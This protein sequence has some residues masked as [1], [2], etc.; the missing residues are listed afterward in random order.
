M[1]EEQ[2]TVEDVAGPY[3]QKVDDR[4]E[5]DKSVYEKPKGKVFPLDLDF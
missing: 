1:A 3:K 4:F 2:S 5:F